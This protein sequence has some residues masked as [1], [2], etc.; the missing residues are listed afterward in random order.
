MKGTAMNHHEQTPPTTE[1]RLAALE[2]GFGKSKVATTDALKVIIET[3]QELR[4]RLC[5]LPPFCENGES[6]KDG[7]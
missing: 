7:N 5:D 4:S 3:L 6:A 2:Q 1:D